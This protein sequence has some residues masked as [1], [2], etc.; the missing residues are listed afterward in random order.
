MELCFG[1]HSEFS[2]LEN[3]FSNTN[4]LGLVWGEERMPT[5]IQFIDMLA[6]CPYLE[7]L[8]L[9]SAPIQEEDLWA[10]GTE[11]LPRMVVTLPSLNSLTLNWF[12]NLQTFCCMLL[13]LHAPN[14]EEFA[15]T[16]MDESMDGSQ[17]ID[18]S[19]AI[20][21]LGRGEGLG[22]CLAGVKRLRVARV[23]CS[24][25]QSWEGL[26]G[27]LCNLQSL[28]IVHRPW[29][30]DPSQGEAHYFHALQQTATQGKSTSTQ[31][32]CPHLE[33]LWVSGL[34]EAMVERLLLERQRQG[35]PLQRIF[36]D[37]GKDLWLGDL[38]VVVEEY[39]EEY[40]EHPA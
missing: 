6:S 33:E 18:M 7:T 3:Q 22:A 38:G 10:N 19:D 26:Y 29:E 23:R 34:D 21:L 32:L 13:L 39:L 24:S 28:R 40:Y 2:R 36:V 4:N 35:Y 11:V 37:Q 14:L 25:L 1:E 8:A 27:R 9:D 20:A 16:R 30:D 15:L 12:N 17:A 5:I 31:F